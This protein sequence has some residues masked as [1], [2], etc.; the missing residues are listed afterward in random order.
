MTQRTLAIKLTP[1]ASSDRIGDTRKLPDGTEQLAV[2][3]TAVPENGKANE[4]M[5]RLLSKHLKIPVSRL[6]VTKGA[7]SRNKLVE[8]S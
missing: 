8:I 2:Y 6:A 5:L 7:T 3:V 4:A 1:K